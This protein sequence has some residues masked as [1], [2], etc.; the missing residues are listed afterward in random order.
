[1]A[2]KT[3]KAQIILKRQVIT[4]A[5]VTPKFKEFLK[6]ELQENVKFYQNK[7]SD[8]TARLNAMPPADPAG[9]QL[10]SEKQEAEQYIQSESSQRTFINDLEMNSEYS[11]GPVEGFV[12]V[13][14]GDNLYEKLGGVEIIVKDGIIT[15]IVV[16][17]S[18]FDKVTTKT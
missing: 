11:Q 10:Q 15:K 4:K 7:L 2:E 3:K 9:G 16:Q 1:M 17:K 12:T 5:I 8:L 14:T 13:S 6:Y 18:Q